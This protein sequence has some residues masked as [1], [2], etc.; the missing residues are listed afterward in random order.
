[1]LAGQPNRR[2]VDDRSQS[3]EVFDEQAIEQSFISVEQ[4]DQSNV[5][6]ERLALRKDV[7]EFAGDLLLNGQYRWRKK[8][9]QPESHPFA[10]GECRIFVPGRVLKNFAGCYTAISIVHK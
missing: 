3:F 5:L 2:R 6:L 10:S 1:L 8:S 7:F 9:G 4:C